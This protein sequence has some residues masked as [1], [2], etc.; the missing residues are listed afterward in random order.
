MFIAFHSKI[1][2]LAETQA[3][4]LYYVWP[5]DVI[6]NTVTKICIKSLHLIEILRLLYYYCFFLPGINIWPVIYSVFNCCHNM[7]L[8][9]VWFSSYLYGG[10]LLCFTFSFSSSAGVCW[11]YVCFAHLSRLIHSYFVCVLGIKTH[12]CRHQGPA[13]GIVTPLLPT[14]FWEWV[15]HWIEILQ[16]C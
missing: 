8:L 15:S 1:S 9:F 13:L 14:L 12:M 5:H 2:Y 7:S 4:I 6:F 16:G 10:S 3:S 11:L